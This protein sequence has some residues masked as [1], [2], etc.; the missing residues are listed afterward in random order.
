MR[1]PGARLCRSRPACHVGLHGQGLVG[2][3]AAAHFDLDLN[4]P[5]IGVRDDEDVFDPGALGGLEADAPVDAAPN[6]VHRVHRVEAADQ[7][8][9]V[10]AL[11]RVHADDNAVGARV[12]R[13]GDVELEGR[14]VADVGAHELP[15]DPDVGV[16]MD[17]AEPEPEHL[18]LPAF[19]YLDGAVI[20]GRARV[21]VEH[22][23]GLRSDPLRAPSAWHHDRRVVSAAIREPL[24]CF[25]DL[26]GVSAELP[27]S[28]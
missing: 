19:G 28:G 27:W 7:R 18:A 2:R 24:L 22:L 13:A 21:V 3:P 5:G 17:P 11:P 15:V 8:I 12:A 4:G 14:Q 10:L 9:H 26:L 16:A 1:L 6:D 23:F 20:P 25:S